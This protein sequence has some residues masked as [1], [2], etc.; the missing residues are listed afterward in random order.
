VK[1]VNRPPGITGTLRLAVRY[2]D[3]VESSIVDGSGWIAKRLT[4]LH[5]LLDGD[6]SD[7]DRRAIE[8]EIAALSNEQG[9]GCG[10]PIHNRRPR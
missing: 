9:L 3:S 8:E 2:R 5:S 10:G 4:H 7:E 6:L 1:V